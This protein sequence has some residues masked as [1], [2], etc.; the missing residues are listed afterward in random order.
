MHTEITVT[1]QYELS[2]CEQHNLRDRNKIQVPARYRDLADE[3]KQKLKQQKRKRAGSKTAITKR[4]HQ[5]LELI[6]EFGSRT[7][8]SF[9]HDELKHVLHEAI[10][11]HEELMSMLEE[12]NE[13]FSDDW[14]EDLKLVVST[15]SGDVN[16]YFQRR[17]DD[18]PS[19]VASSVRRQCKN[20]L[21]TGTISGETGDSPGISDEATA[22]E[23]TVMQLSA[24]FDENLSLQDP[25]TDNLEVLRDPSG[26]E[27]KH[28]NVF[29]FG[30]ASRS[31]LLYPDQVLDSKGVNSNHS[32]VLSA[33]R[34]G[35]KDPYLKGDNNISM[36]ESMRYAEEIHPREWLIKCPLRWIGQ[37]R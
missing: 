12:D 21:L 7:K 26:L 32:G 33:E 18:D 1:S 6:Q 25:Y 37:W 8:I 34:M 14:I 36:G 35:S 15:C 5:I 10:V 28:S 27:L 30:D 20:W 24:M 3:N 2:A 13:Q 29:G 23:S 31:K 16:E 19:S 4:V 22:T 17:V 9:L 11:R